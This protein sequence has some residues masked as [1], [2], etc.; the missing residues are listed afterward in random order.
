MDQAAGDSPCFH[1]APSHAQARK[2][3]RRHVA[4][5]AEEQPEK[6]N[7]GPSWA[8]N[9]VFA[10]SR[11]RRLTGAVA[12]AAT[13]VEGACN[14]ALLKFAPAAQQDTA[15]WPNFSVARIGARS[16]LIDLSDA[17][18]PTQQEE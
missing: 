12:V 4:A 11:I 15:E 7:L 1:P 8:T 6:R 18:E 14:S 5:R 16:Q 2:T 10:A 17:S 3:V 9:L 13:A